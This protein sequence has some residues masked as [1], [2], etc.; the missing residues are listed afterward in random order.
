MNQNL[1]RTSR[2]EPQNQSAPKNMNYG[3]NFGSGMSYNQNDVFSTRDMGP[4]SYQTPPNQKTPEQL[5]FVSFFTLLDL[6]EFAQFFIFRIWSSQSGKRASRIG[7]APSPLT[8]IAR[9]IV[10]MRINFSTCAASF[11]RSASKFTA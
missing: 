1:K 4:T 5:A 8:L 3:G 11:F 2:F 10:N 7:N 6:I 9:L